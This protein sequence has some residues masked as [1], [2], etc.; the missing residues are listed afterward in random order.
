V[1]AVLVVEAVLLLLEELAVE[2]V[3]AVEVAGQDDAL[4]EPD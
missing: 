1:W 4:L 3:S 2:A